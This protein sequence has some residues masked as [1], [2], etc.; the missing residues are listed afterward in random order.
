MERR[1]L[2]RSDGYGAELQVSTLAPERRQTGADRRST[3]TLAPKPSLL[4]RRLFRLFVF[5]V[6]LCQAAPTRNWWRRDW[7]ICFNR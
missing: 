1:R 6:T 7:W 3:R 2:Q 5:F 4:F